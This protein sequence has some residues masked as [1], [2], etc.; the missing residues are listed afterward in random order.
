M[1]KPPFAFSAV[2]KHASIQQKEVLLSLKIF[3][4]TSAVGSFV[5]KL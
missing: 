2:V 1:T 5:L 4:I 3:V